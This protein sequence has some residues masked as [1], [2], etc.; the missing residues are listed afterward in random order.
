MSTVRRFRSLLIDQADIRIPG[1]SVMTFAL[2]RHLAEHEAIAPHRHRWCQALLYLSQQG[3]Q[4]VDGAAVQVNPGTLILMPPGVAHAFRRSGRAAP[5]CLMIN[6]RVRRARSRSV[7]V[8]SLTRSEL[9]EI[10]HHLARLIRLQQTPGDALAWEGATLV[11]LTLMLCLRTA[12]WLGQ[13]AGATAIRPSRAISGLLAAMPMAGSLAETVQRSGYHRDHLNRLV[14]GET[15]LSLGQFRARQRLIRAKELL[16]H[17]VRVGEVA[18][19]V[20]LPDQGYFA[21]WFRRQTGQA[22]SAWS[23]RPRAAQP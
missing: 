7:A 23:R 18:N 8:C 22:P 12:G 1:L 11:L 6:F 15:G 2:H 10:R 17:G 16:T 3:R 13:E 4:A 19:A 21:R 20:G 9:S 14:R 5:L